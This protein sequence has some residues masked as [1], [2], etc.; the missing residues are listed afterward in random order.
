MIP[1]TDQIIAY[2][3]P[4]VPAEWITAHRLHPQRLLFDVDA[5]SSP[6]GSV[7][8]L[9]PYARGFLDAAKRMLQSTDAH[10]A[11]VIATTVCDQMRRAT[12]CIDTDDAKA[13]FLLNV[14][15]T[16]QTPASRILY[17]TELE[18]L[19]RFLVER[20]GQAPSR[21]DLVQAILDADRRRAMVRAL[22]RRHSAR[23]DDAIPIAV[24]GG[25]LTHHQ[26]DVFDRI[27]DAGGRIVLDA[28]GGGERALPAPIDPERARR[29]SLDA[30]TAA[31][32]DTIPD[33]S[34]RPN[35]TLYAWLGE[36]LEERSVR[37]IVFVHQIWCDTWHAEAQ[38][39]RDWS[40]RPLLIL[41]LNEA[42][43]ID[44]HIDTRIQAF[45]ETLR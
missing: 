34:R 43:G 11:G 17:R 37:G 21:E 44:H 19:G 8:G 36:R 1:N 18:R 6:T 22:R 10:V 15:A 32:F 29:D 31:Y 39:M 38:R 35:D 26:L 41:N 40:A 42:S 5:A 3:C 2:C 27:E 28:T 25:P 9:C 12:E 23:T 13:V 45:I 7:V 24:V 16:W 4:F 14:P 30:L 20:G 33:A